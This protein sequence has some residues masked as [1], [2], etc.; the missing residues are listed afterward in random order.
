MLEKV[1]GGWRI[2]GTSQKELRMLEEIV[3]WLE[4]L[5]DV[6]GIE[7]ARGGSRL[8]DLGDVTV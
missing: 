5:R 4:D 2:L 3:G 6:T 1:L 7:D 8:E